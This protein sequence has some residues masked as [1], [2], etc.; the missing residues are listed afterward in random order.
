MRGP[1]AAAF[2]S[3][4][5]TCWP[6][7]GFR[8]V[9]EASM[10][11]SRFAASVAPERERVGAVE[12][13]ER[14]DAAVVEEAEAAHLIALVAVVA[15]AEE[16]DRRHPEHADLLVQVPQVRD[17][18]LLGLALDRRLAGRPEEAGRGID[19]RGSRC[20]CGRRP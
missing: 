4:R 11:C 7:I 17:L 9:S 19:A 15:G 3:S 1:A 18:E 10:N 2:G 20:S 14:V 13:E 6:T 12:A 8:F 5:V 16:R